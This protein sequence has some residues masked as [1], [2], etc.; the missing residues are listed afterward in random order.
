MNSDESAPHF[1]CGVCIDSHELSCIKECVWGQFLYV[2]AAWQ[3]LYISLS[4]V[5]VC[6][7][8]CVCVRSMPTH[9]VCY[10]SMIMRRFPV[11]PPPPSPSLHSQT[12]G[13]GD[14]LIQPHRVVFPPH[15]LSSVTLRSAHRAFFLLVF[16]TL[17]CQ[18]LGGDGAFLTP[19]VNVFCPIKGSGETSAPPTRNNNKGHDSRPL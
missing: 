14:T 2:W 11:L 12:R 6:A 15:T 7:S 9:A 13:E 4:C 3:S 10:I 1:K 8:V 19:H 17:D 16:L 18:T 5:W